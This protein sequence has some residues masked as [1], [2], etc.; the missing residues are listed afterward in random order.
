MPV[1]SQGIDLSRNKMASSVAIRA[2]VRRR[3]DKDSLTAQINSLRA[4][5]SRVGAFL[6]Q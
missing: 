1:S 5:Q 2:G 4:P 6:A 3:D